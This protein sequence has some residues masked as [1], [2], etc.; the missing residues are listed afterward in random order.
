[1]NYTIKAIK[2]V[3]SGMVV[4]NDVYSYDNKLII[5]KGTELTEKAI[6]RLKFYSVKE[7]F[8]TISQE[9]VSEETDTYFE[10]IR[11]TKEFKKFNQSFIKSTKKLEDELNNIIGEESQD[12]DENILLK[13]VNNV[14]SEGRNGLHVFD[15]LHSMRENDDITY[16][17]SLNVSV[18]CNIIGS[19]LKFSKEDIKVL[20]LCGLL[21][22]IGKLL[23]P[24]EIINKPGKLNDKEYEI[25]K[26][27]T[28][29]GYE[30]L[31]DKNIDK[32]IKN[33]VLMHHEA[34]DGSGYPSGLRANEI[35]E[36]AKIVSIADVYDAMTSARA[37]REPICPFKVM[38]KFE[39]EKLFK[40]D[41]HYLLTF[42]EG[43]TLTYMHNQVQLS[44][45]TI[46]EIILLNSQFPSRPMIK[47]GNKFID[48]TKYRGLSIERIL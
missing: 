38:E 33:S 26:A 18:I 41:L 6:E 20:S 30:V 11:E 7:V 28:L 8:I 12:I 44:N 5:G 2:D 9:E 34:C 35:D 24:P 13:D 29:K 22:D 10:R 1:M 43:I 47:S 42:M 48:L 32:R 27:H 45:G 14:L 46:G 3:K 23:I 25:V 17:H 19:W 39:D 16:V 4:A 15:M 31:K 37:Y 21:H 36:F 40:F